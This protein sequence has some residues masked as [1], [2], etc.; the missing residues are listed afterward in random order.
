MT[1]LAVTSQILLVLL[2]FVLILVVLLQRG[3]GGGLA[4]ALGG[5]G[6]QS[7]FGTRAGDVFTKITVVIATLWFV[8]AGVS[9]ILLRASQDTRAA[10]VNDGDAAVEAAADEAEPVL[11]AVDVPEIPRG[12]DE[13]APEIDPLL[14]PTNKPDTL[15]PPKPAPSL[16]DGE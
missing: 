3:R 10:G 4:G 16:P 5:A 15:T 11:P 14:N 8:L 6:G 13:V 12:D 2:S 9:G 7:A 1:A